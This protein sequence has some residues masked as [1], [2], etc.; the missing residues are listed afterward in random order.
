MACFC[1]LVLTPIACAVQ[2]ARDDSAISSAALQGR[3]EVA[4]DQ[5]GAFACSSTETHVT[6]RPDL[7]NP[8]FTKTG[9]CPP[10]Q[11][12]QLEGCGK[13]AFF[14]CLHSCSS[15]GISTQISQRASCS[16]A[17]DQVCEQATVEECQTF[18]DQGVSGACGSLGRMYQAGNRV[19]ADLDKAKHLLGVGCDG[20]SAVACAVLQNDPR[21][22][23]GAER[24]ALLTHSCQRWTAAPMDLGGSLACR[25]I[26]RSRGDF[27]TAVVGVALQKLC[28]SGA[29]SCGEWKDFAAANRLSTTP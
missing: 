28:T 11:M 19:P 4:H 17:D 9:P 5:F 1:T 29:G 20:G 7:E 21:L 14:N 12:Y 27:P 15:N 13:K 25:E 22:L 23:K 24:L 3:S 2:P 6:E 10:F 26:A 8:N 16:P 18:C